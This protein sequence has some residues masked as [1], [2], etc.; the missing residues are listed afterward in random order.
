MD[1]HQIACFHNDCSGSLV[2]QRKDLF[3]RSD[4]FLLD[5]FFEPIS[6]LLRDEN[7]L[8]LLATFGVPD[9]QF[10][11]INIPWRE[12]EHLA[13][14]HPTTGHKFQHETVS[15]FHRPENDFVNNLLF[16]NAPMNDLGRFEHLPEHRGATGILKFWIDGVSDEIEE[17]CQG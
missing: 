4:S 17:G 3:I 8:E 10:S 1:T 16:K 13:D 11:A 6:D 14:S 15:G 7:H 9:D 5:I 12:I 2:G